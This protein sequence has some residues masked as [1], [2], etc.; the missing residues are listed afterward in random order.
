[1]NWEA[2]GATAELLGGIGVI[3][4]L[5]Y[6]AAQ[7]RQ[8]TRSVRAASYQAVTTSLSQLSG[9]FGQS[10]QTSRI[11]LVGTT[12]LE[13]LTREERGQFTLLMVSLFRSYENIFYQHNRGMIEDAV[14]QGWENSMRRIF[15]S[16]GVQA[17]WPG[18]RKDCQAEFRDFLEASTPAEVGIQ[19]FWAGSA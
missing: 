1:M 13:H 3:V 19:T 12:D 7:I 4:S 5:F 10:P 9:A 14:W 6:L 8:N 2:V 18:W 11:I 16:P 17:W 15:W